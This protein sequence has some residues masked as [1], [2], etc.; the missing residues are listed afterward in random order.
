M[1]PYSLWA[2]AALLFLLPPLAHAQ[3]PE[4][5]YD[6][7]ER[8]TAVDYPGTEEDL[9]YT[10]YGDTD[11]VKEIDV[12]K[13]NAIY[14]YDEDG[15]LAKEAY[16][17]SPS[18]DRDYTYYP[19]GML[20]SIA[21][22]D[23]KVTYEY[24]A[25]GMVSKVYTEAGEMVTY[26]AYVYNPDGS[27][28]KASNPAGY[29]EYSYDSDGNII[30]ETL[31]DASTGASTGVF[32]EYDRYGNIVKASD[33]AGNDVSWEYENVD[34]P[35]ASAECLDENCTEFNLINDTC[36]YQRLSSRTIGNY[37]VSIDYS[38]GAAVYSSNA[39]EGGHSLVSVYN[40]D[41]LLTEDDDF[42]YEYDAEGNLYKTT[43]KLDGETAIY[44]TNDEGLVSHAQ[45]SSGLLEYYYYDPFGKVIR[46]DQTLPGE[47]RAS[48]YY[49]SKP[50]DMGSMVE[51]SQLRALTG[52]AISVPGYA[53][54]EAAAPGKGSKP[55][56]EGPAAG[57]GPDYLTYAIIG[58]CALIAVLIINSR[59]KR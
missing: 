53:G 29:T 24:D 20:K 59:R 33:S 1:N 45:Y 37:R 44:T 18:K 40:D 56:T 6:S 30:Q 9:S 10:Y 35:C 36:T 4:T 51:E 13:G 2:I 41:G 3:E 52:G 58:I 15:N 21:S 17:S 46:V 28:K 16:P 25:T 32:Y 49:A 14:Q 22:Q 50:G 11:A 8:L 57:G 39:G 54:S 55:K 5:S 48:V 34:Y 26:E 31:Y 43:S 27:L 23:S 38:T 19:D 12:G 42:Y 47:T 7:L